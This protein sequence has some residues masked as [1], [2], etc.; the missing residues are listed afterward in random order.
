MTK[1]DS[2]IFSRTRH[3][4]GRPERPYRR[5]D[6]GA[7]LGGVC[8]GLARR[9]GVETRPVRLMA[10]VSVLALGVGVPAYFALWL[11]VTRRGET[12][13]IFSRTSSDKREKEILFVVAVGA[14]TLLIALQTLGRHAFGVFL[15]LMTLSALGALVTWRGCSDDERDHL[16]EVLTDVVTRTSS[17]SDRWQSVALRTGA[18]VIMTL[19]G[20]SLLSRVGNESGA[21]AYVL[22]GA[23][24][25]VGGLFVL[26]APWWIRTIRD[27]SFE[28]RARARAQDRADMAAHVHDSVMQTLSLIQRSAHDPAE[29]TR[30][31]RL[32]ERDLRS[33]LANPEAFGTSSSPPTT[34]RQSALAI[35]REV[36][37]NYGV[38]VDVVVVG[39]CVLDESITALLAAGREATLNAAK[40]S[41]A[42]NVSLYV[43]AEP[44]LVSMFVRDQGCGFDIDTVSSDRQGIRRSIRERMTRHGGSAVI[45]SVPEFGTEVELRLPVHS[46]A[47]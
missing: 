20:M 42:S 22:V 47:Q 26:F 16:R 45:R 43:E 7:V 11:G 27:L 36:E 19:W 21:A 40:W 24:A 38:G 37:D 23:G 29:V 25:L 2:A 39:D 35:E 9:L 1:R 10:L 6:D 44:G 46:R 12:E 18:G 31:A 15:W 30:L 28:R 4:V 32:Q 41:G 5:N 13:S 17:R 34:L 14:I 3:E 8:G 33:W